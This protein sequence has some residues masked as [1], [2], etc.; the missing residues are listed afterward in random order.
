MAPRKDPTYPA[1]FYANLFSITERRV[2][3]LA[4]QGTIPKEGRGRYPLIE[5][6]KGYVNF[7]QTRS[8]DD[9]NTDGDYRTQKV[10]LTKAQA[11]AQE[12]KNK[13]TKH[14]VVPVA[15]INFVLGRVANE[16]A[17]VHDGLPVELVR[18]LKLSAD[19]AE[20]I[21]A[22]V[23][24]SGDSIANLADGDFLEIALDEFIRS[25]N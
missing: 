19:Q 16:I 15:F 20:I 14:E 13:I 9:Q 12:L 17:G 8:L 5:T 23:S 7:L 3:Q 10:R 4:K 21:K 11:E 2:Q 6:I 1:K 25:T 18:R 22:Q 24:R